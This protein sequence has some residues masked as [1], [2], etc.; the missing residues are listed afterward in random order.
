MCGL[1][2]GVLRDR[3]M[4][5]EEWQYLCCLYTLSAQAW[6]GGGGMKL[7]VHR[8]CKEKVFLHSTV[9]EF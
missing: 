6:G 5:G 2:E 1:E 8:V 7:G 9:S 4:E 3:M